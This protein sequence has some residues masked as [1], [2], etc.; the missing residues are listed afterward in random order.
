MKDVL[1]SILLSSEK[2]ISSVLIAG[3]YFIL[4][5]NIEP[6]TFGKYSVIES[7]AIIFT[8]TSLMSIDAIAFD[9]A[10][11]DETKAESIFVSAIL[12]KIIFS[13][14]G[15]SLF[16]IVSIF[17]LDY[18]PYISAIIGSL[19]VFKSGGILQYRLIAQE[20]IL[21]NVK[22]SLGATLVSIL[23][24]L[25]LIK[26]NSYWLYPAFFIIDSIVL[27]VLLFYEAKIISKVKLFDFNIALNMMRTSKFFILSSFTILSFGK[28][29]QIILSKLMNFEIVANYSLAM[30]VIGAFVLVSNAFNLVFARNVSIN[31][32]SDKSLYIIHVRKMLL[33]TIS[34]GFILSIA[35]CFLSPIVIDY[36]YND[37][38]L[39][40]SNLVRLASPLIFLI[41]VSSSVGKILIT[42]G[43]GAFAL[44]RNSIGL[45]SMIALCFILIPIYGVDGAVFS[46]LLSWFI[47]SILLVLLYK[48]TRFIYMSLL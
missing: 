48:K 44:I 19:I 18:S 38:Y 30:K 27:F 45:L 12:M 5:Q 22:L 4:A 15:Y 41:F 7:L 39:V 17:I 34:V 40:A 11:K 29:D 37:R 46:A 21:L 25:Y 14:I 24:K 33:F 35:S 42:E 26:V 36:F 28:I 20:K 6:D 23:I 31:N 16:L 8:F 2:Y 47:S 9:M 43:L 10:L 1:R 3:S 13:L 32:S